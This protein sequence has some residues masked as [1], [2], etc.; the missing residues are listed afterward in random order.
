MK[1]TLIQLEDNPV[2]LGLTLDQRLAWNVQVKAVKQSWVKRIPILRQ[3][4]SLFW[5]IFPKVL[6]DFYKGFPI[7]VE[8][9][10]NL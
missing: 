1:G 4:T 5:V 3:F 9:F 6:L 2:V 7:S 8:R 10:Y